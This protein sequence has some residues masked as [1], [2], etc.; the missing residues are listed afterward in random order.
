ML[1]ILVISTLGITIG[2][3]ATLS[4]QAVFTTQVQQVT[5]HVQTCPE[6]ILPDVFRP[7]ETTHQPKGQLYTAPI[8]GEKP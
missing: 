2:I 5:Y 3:T 7:V 6:P 1:R 8:F 4:Y